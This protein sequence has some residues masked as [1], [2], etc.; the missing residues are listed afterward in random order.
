LWHTEIITQSIPRK[1]FGAIT[2]QILQ[3]LHH[4]KFHAQIVEMVNVYPSKNWVCCF[5]SPHADITVVKSYG[6]DPKCAQNFN[7]STITEYFNMHKALDDKHNGISLEHNWNVDE[8]WYQ[9]GG[10][11]KGDNSK[12]IFLKSN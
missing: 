9:M 12:I 10:G 3:P 6:L 5:I 1:S 7:K 4:Q 8:K 11:Q 2:T